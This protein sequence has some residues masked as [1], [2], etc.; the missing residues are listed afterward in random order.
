M[1]HTVGKN[2]KTERFDVENPK[3]GEVDGNL[4][5]HES[6]NN[7][8]YYDF[9]KENLFDKEGDAAPKYVQKVLKQAWAIK[10]INKAKEYLGL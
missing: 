7:K 10:A 9:E 8:W 2:G 6:N 1:S 3:P 4:H 5:Y